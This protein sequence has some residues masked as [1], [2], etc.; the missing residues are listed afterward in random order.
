MRLTLIIATFAYTLA[1]TA[2]DAP[3]DITDSIQNVSL[4]RGS[5]SHVHVDFIPQKGAQPSGHNT[6]ERGVS[7]MLLSRVNST[8]T[9]IGIRSF[10]PSELTFD[11]ANRWSIP[12]GEELSPLELRASMIDRNANADE[13]TGEC[14]TTTSGTSGASGRAFDNMDVNFTVAHNTSIKSMS[15]F[16]SSLSCSNNKTVRVNFESDHA[17]ATL[18][19]QYR[20]TNH[21]AWMDLHSKQFLHLRSGIRYSEDLSVTA[22][23]DKFTLRVA[24]LDTCASPHPLASY[25]EEFSNTCDYVWL[26]L[27]IVSWVA[28]ALT[29]AFLGRLCWQWWPITLRVETST[30]ELSDVS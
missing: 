3:P 5:C 26:T 20:T 13:I 10:E 8:W 12:V 7:L 2:C 30:T 1:T 29:L 27:L 18:L 4:T 9:Q 22:S 19:L 17:N 25:E 24:L 15:L 6:V 21:T 23:D 14:A 11:V 16:E 28:I